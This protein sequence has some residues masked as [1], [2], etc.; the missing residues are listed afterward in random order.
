MSTILLPQQVPHTA[1]RSCRHSR[2]RIRSKDSEKIRFRVLCL[3]FSCHAAAAGRVSRPG[4]AVRVLVAPMCMN[5][6]WRLFAG[7][8]ERPF[9]MSES[10]V[11]G[12]GEARFDVRNGLY[13]D[14]ER[15]LMVCRVG[16]APRCFRLTCL[17]SAF[18]ALFC[19]PRVCA[20]R[21]SRHLDLL[22]VCAT[23]PSL[24]MR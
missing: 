23:L 20:R 15:P 6:R 12:N 16:F 2:T 21:D 9:R 5:M 8:P 7:M 4:V 3:R 14:A 13:R 22:M 10:V 18:C 19:G 24:P 11:W 17:W 1:G